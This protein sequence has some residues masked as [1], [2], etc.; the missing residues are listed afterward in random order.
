MI[1]QDPTEQY[2]RGYRLRTVLLVTPFAIVLSGLYLGIRTGLAGSSASAIE[3][4]FIFGSL[5]A[6]VIIIIGGGLY[7][8]ANP[9]KSFRIHWRTVMA[10]ALLGAVLMAFVYPRLDASWLTW[11]V[12]YIADN[13]R[14]VPTRLAVLGGVDGLL[15][16][17]GMGVAIGYLDPA[18]THF[19]RRGLVRYSVLF[20]LIGGIF[21]L[22]GLVDMSGDTGDRF[23]G[24][25]GLVCLGLVKLGVNWWDRRARKSG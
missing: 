7:V 9:D 11:L 16:G 21:I 20:V 10:S 24:L 25:F 12:P 18:A 2:R 23:S 22:A 17:A 3:Q 4:D 15:Y 8:L 19:T 5:L 13:I 6:L 1:S 14:D